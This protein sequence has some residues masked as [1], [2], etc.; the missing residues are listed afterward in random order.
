MTT[1]SSVVFIYLPFYKYVRLSQLFPAFLLSK[2]GQKCRLPRSDVSNNLSSYI[3]LSK[4][5]SSCHN[6]FQLFYSQGVAKNV[7]C[8]VLMCLVSYLCA[9]AS[10]QTFRFL[11]FR[12]R[13]SFYHSSVKPRAWFLGESFYLLN[14]CPGFTAK[15]DIAYEYACVNK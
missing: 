11:I 2:Y 5:I 14:N 15:F 13:R 3:S 4:N 1:A 9:L 12:F 10:F 7:Y 6:G 8:L